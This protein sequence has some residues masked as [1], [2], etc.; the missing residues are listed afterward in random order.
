M[1]DKQDPSTPSPS[2]LADLIALSEA[3]VGAYKV[4][5]VLD[6]LLNS[7]LKL[8]HADR[9]AIL[10]FEGRSIDI[11]RTLVRSRD[12]KKGVIDHHLN[13]LVAGW[14][15]RHQRPYRTEDVIRDQG[16]ANPPASIR[17]IGP[18]LG[19]PLRSAGALTGVI[20]LANAR[21]GPS[22][23]DETLRLG[24]ILA[25]L[26]SQFID[27]AKL[28]ESLFRENARLKSD[29]S[30][31][32]GIG[33]IVGESPSM[34]ELR[35]R[36]PMIAAARATVLLTGE[37]GSG[38]ELIA[39]AIHY[40]SGR[41]GGPFVAV[42]CAAIPA[43]LFESEVFGHDKGAFTGAAQS[44]KGKFELADGGTL[45]LDEISE[46]PVELH[47]KLL[48]AI[49]DRRYYRLG[50][51]TEV[52]VDIRIIAASSRNLQEAVRRRSFSD[53]L[54]HRLNVLPVIIPPLRERREDVPILAEHFLTQFTSG[55]KRFRD[56]AMEVLK[57]LPWVGNVRELRN[58]AERVAILVEEQ[59]IGRASLERILVG[60]ELG[61][62]SFDDMGIDPNPSSYFTPGNRQSPGFQTDYAPSSD[63]QQPSNHPPSSHPLSVSGENLLERSERE[64]IAKAIAQSGGN[65]AEAARILGI[66]RL[67]LRRRIDKYRLGSGS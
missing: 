25:S 51:P 10:L 36:I 62:R 26:A 23:T 11:V 47:P 65:I 15:H 41:A 20:H 61:S 14:V 1:T 50:S 44:Q 2:A 5:E 49:E 43:M 9:G 27:R 16:Y 29:L 67:A 31:R 55:M 38:K 32:W 12:G 13:Q 24:N 35:A 48:R 54:Y 46:M 34:A 22:F 57:S 17:E 7:C 21:T 52:S 64:L 40:A 58:V 18:S 39:R 66:D 8:C 42:N 45:F 53:A 30:Q 28:H 3:L 60:E 37:T 56:D 4:D 33:D 63:L 19:L 6:A 59:E